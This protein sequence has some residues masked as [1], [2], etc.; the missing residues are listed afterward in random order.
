[1]LK[2]KIVFALIYDL[3]LLLAVWFVAAIPFVIW[4]GE[5]FHTRPLALLSFQ[6]YLLGVTYLYLSYFWLQTGQTPGLRTWH[7]RLQRTDDYLLTRQDATRRF[8]FSLLSV[9]TLGLG[10]LWMLRGNKNQTLH[11][12]LADTYIVATHPDTN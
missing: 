4:Q 3:L 9:A 5:G 7:L 2:A 8:A 6:L 11:D 12:K 1:M 10:W